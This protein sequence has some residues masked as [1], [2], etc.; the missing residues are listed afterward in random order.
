MTKRRMAECPT[1]N[2]S[3]YAE[4]WASTAARYSSVVLPVPWHALAQRLERH[5][6]DP[7]SIRIRYSPS[8]GLPREWLRC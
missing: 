6:L 2:G 8:A 3:I 7:A 1:M 4:L 5:T